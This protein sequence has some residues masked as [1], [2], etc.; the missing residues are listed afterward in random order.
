MQR[1]AKMA[2]KLKL[3]KERMGEIALM[4][5]RKKIRKESITL[6]ATQMRRQIGNTAKELSIS[7]EE[8]SAFAENILSDAFSEILEE[9]VK[10]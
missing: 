10:K 6:D 8:A 9:I 4:Y 1:G 3:S 5:V 2:D 7:H